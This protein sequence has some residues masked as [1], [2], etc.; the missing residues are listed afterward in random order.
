MADDYQHDSASTVIQNVLNG[1]RGVPPYWVD[2]WYGSYHSRYFS[3]QGEP[4]KAFEVF[5]EYYDDMMTPVF[6]RRFVKRG[7]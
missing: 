5:L 7:W 3:F 4:A 1:I 2:Y 6:M